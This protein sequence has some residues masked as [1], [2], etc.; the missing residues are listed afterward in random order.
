MMLQLNKQYL[1]NSF[2]FKSNK[3]FQFLAVLRFVGIILFI[4]DVNIKLALH[5]NF[6]SRHQHVSWQ[7]HDQPKSARKKTCKKLKWNYD[8]INSSSKSVSS[9]GYLSNINCL[10]FSNCYHSAKSL[11][12]LHFS[13][14]TCMCLHQIV[15]E[16]PKNEE[17]YS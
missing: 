7:I 11:K 17:K 15:K 6:G 4:P 10:F 1:W 3:V 12:F 13:K 9:T 16:S 5:H 8:C 14:R 2:L